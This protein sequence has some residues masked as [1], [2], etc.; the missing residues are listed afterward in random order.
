M[1]S[2]KDADH[3]RVVDH[4]S[5]DPTARTPRMSSILSCSFVLL[6]VG[7]HFLIANKF[8]LHNKWSLMRSNLSRRSLHLDV[9]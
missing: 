9:G 4:L 7:E 5:S 8:L 6:L 3:A 1:V 2:L